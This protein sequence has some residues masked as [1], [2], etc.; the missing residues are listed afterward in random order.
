MP[1]EKP[2]LIRHYNCQR[3]SHTVFFNRAPTR[4]LAAL[5]YWSSWWVRLP[6]YDRT[7]AHQDRGI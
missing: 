5:A 2:N 7:H 1:K 3:F 4:G 6:E